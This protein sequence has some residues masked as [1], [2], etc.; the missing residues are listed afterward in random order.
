MLPLMPLLMMPIGLELSRWPVRAR[1][2][3]FVLLL[4]SLAI[5]AQNM[6]FLYLG[7]EIEGVPRQ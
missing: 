1:T 6:I 4:L 7:P 5:I 2:T 3:T